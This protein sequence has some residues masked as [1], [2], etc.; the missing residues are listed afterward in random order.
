MT[1]GGF[2]EGGELLAMHAMQGKPWLNPTVT[3]IWI[4]PGSGPT[5]MNCFL[6]FKYSWRRLTFPPRCSHCWCVAC[7]RATRLCRWGM[8]GQC[9]PSLTAHPSHR[10]VTMAQQ[11]GKVNG[12]KSDQ[13]DC[14]GS[15]GSKEAKPAMSLAKFF[16]RER[17]L[18]LW[19]FIQWRAFPDPL[20]WFSKL[21]I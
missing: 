18:L 14:A 17:F 11:E 1:L 6:P 13:G 20:R 5:S 2:G 10:D 19:I 7:A 16:F 21:I 12:S 8:C 3:W 15:L 4:K 9:W